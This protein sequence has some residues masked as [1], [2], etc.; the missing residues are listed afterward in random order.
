MK[1][2][3][4]R[5]LSF[6]LL[7]AMLAELL[8]AS[9]LAASKITL[10]SG[11]AAPSS[12]Y[13]GHSYTLKVAGE[14]VKFY[15][16]N[17]KIAT[18][19]A[20]T[21]KMKPTAPG[22][23]KITAKSAKSGKAVATKTFNVLMRSTKVTPDVETVT[24][25]AIGA[26]HTLHASLTPENSTDVIRFF[27]E[28]KTIA[29]I[30][31]TS[32]KITAK[33]F[34]E[35]TINIY[36]KATK[37]TSNANKANK[38]AQVKVIV[39]EMPP[40][41]A[42]TLDPNATPRPMPTRKPS[43]FVALVS[44]Q[45]ITKIYAGETSG[46][47]I[48]FLDQYGE[49]MS[50]DG[51]S[52]ELTTVNLPDGNVTLKPGDS[53]MLGD[54]ILSFIRVGDSYDIM[55]TGGYTKYTYAVK[56]SA[57]PNGY[58]CSRYF[59]FVVCGYSEAHDPQKRSLYI[60]G[61]LGRYQDIQYYMPGEAISLPT[62]EKEGYTFKGWRF[63]R[64]DTNRSLGDLKTM[65]DCN[66]LAT[67]Q[68]VKDGAQTPV[69]TLS[70]D[71]GFEDYKIPSRY[72]TGDQRIA[73]LP[74]LEYEGYTFLGWYYGEM[75]VPVTM[76]HRN[77]TLTARWAKN[78]QLTF[79][80]GYEGAASITQSVAEGSTLPGINP[81]KRENY[82]FL[83][84]KLDGTS[85]PPAVMPDWDV[86]LVAQWK[87]IGYTITID[88][89]DGNTYAPVM[90]DEGAEIAPDIFPTVTREGY[91]FNGWRW[92]DSDV[93]GVMP[94]EDITVTAHWLKLYT[95][96]LDLNDGSEPVRRSL[97][98]GEPL[99][100]PEP[101]AREGY[102][103]LRWAYI[104]DNVPE[105]MPAEDV[106][107]TAI[108]QINTHTISFDA[109]SDTVSRSF[110]DKIAGDDLPVPVK[111]GHTFLEWLYNGNSLTEA[112]L[113]PDRDICLNARWQINKY[114]ISF[115][116]C[117]NFAILKLYGDAILAS[118]LPT[119]TKSGFLFIGWKW[120][121]N[122]VP[123]AMPARDVR[124][125]A[126]WQPAPTA[127]PT[128]APTPVPT[129][130]PTVAP[131]MHKLTLMVLGTVYSEQLLA[132]GEALN[133]PIPSIHGYRFVE[134]SA[135]SD[136][137]PSV[138]GKTDITL[139]AEVDGLE[140]H[141]LTLQADASIDGL[142][143]TLSAYDFVP[144]TKYSLYAGDFISLPQFYPYV[145]VDSW[146]YLFTGWFDQSGNA[147][148][149]DMPDSDL[150]LTAKFKR[151]DT[152]STDMPRHNV[153][154]KSML[155]GVTAPESESVVEGS[156]LPRPDLGWHG[157]YLFVGWYQDERYTVSAPASMGKSDITLYGRWLN[158]RNLSAS[159]I[160]L[161]M[162]LGY[163]LAALGIDLTPVAASPTPAPADT[164][165]PPITPDV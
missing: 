104:A 157:D 49:K 80:M 119:P 7:L 68:W 62:P 4:L 137:I 66:V 116:A 28:D 151:M 69:Y 12:V 139:Y 19:G 60:M 122:D 153:T 91:R 27:S 160:Q 25:G 74:N 41:P 56:F 135:D 134:W 146:P 131:D 149:Q 1:R 110:N 10:K 162:S 32:G 21:G 89:G 54:S 88:A 48:A 138:M 55:V 40:T 65:P 23:V 31:M 84:W 51:I 148:P 6:V 155:A 120:E 152:V 159:D 154:Y 36:A 5:L 63:T 29:T 112:D 77:L 109:C 52:V 15:T 72:L 2:R 165:V 123:A 94:A 22:S 13:A 79:D 100:L 70:L 17:K 46:T 50:A 150:T 76:P 82:Q 126:E 111:E 67:P 53:Y 83:G 90:L 121:G 106:T 64:S 143:D 9:A 136:E 14:H 130:A 142:A 78:Y 164:P 16:S 37:A 113:M 71:S 8:P 147:A 87:R 35:T 145:W 92:G 96:T 11:A 124:L 42:P 115:D 105:Y 45:T 73:N 24:L 129:P 85:E 20:T 158:I 57:N 33:G 114:V 163:D 117:D 81:P 38:L 95:L 156:F 93:P 43:Q 39:K 132:E 47:N 59:T 44:S 58:G 127:V 118:E 30:G 133:L 107:L 141:T 75:E 144:G 26:T 125:T 161:L 140:Q 99:D 34:G 3:P 98:E 97:T 86:R 108:W 101:D 18:I 128:P 103:F 102:T 61:E